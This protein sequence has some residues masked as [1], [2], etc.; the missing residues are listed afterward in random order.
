MGER[1]AMSFF[2]EVEVKSPLAP[3]S[4]RGCEC[5]SW[6][7]EEDGSETEAGAQQNL[8]LFLLSKRMDSFTS[9][10]GS[11]VLP[12]ILDARV[13]DSRYSDKSL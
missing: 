6:I 7:R 13:S 3:L 12:R 9:L 4:I 5:V 11:Q 10:V 2:C 1:C 8:Q